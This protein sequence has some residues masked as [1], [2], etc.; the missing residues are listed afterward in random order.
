MRYLKIPLLDDFFFWGGGGGG[1]F[2]EFGKSC[3]FADSKK[4][5]WDRSIRMG[6]KYTIFGVVLSKSLRVATAA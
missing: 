4:S 5:L 2:P 6:L 1:I 3:S